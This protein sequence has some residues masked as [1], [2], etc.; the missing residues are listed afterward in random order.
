MSSSYDAMWEKLNLDLEAHA[1]LLEVLGKFY[2]DIYMSQQG[3]LRG[4]EYLD[5]VLSEVHG[6]R[7]KEL[8]DAKAL[9]K[10]IVGTFCVFV[11]EEIV[12]AAGGIQVGLC[13]GAE[14]GKRRSRKSA[15]P[16]HLRLDQIICRVQARK[17]L[18]LH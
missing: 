11:P 6:L 13:A 8:Q 15:P 2:G 7:I 14:I 5:F 10:K 18:P 4:M 3:R 17:A 1:G 9:G 16:K 12:L